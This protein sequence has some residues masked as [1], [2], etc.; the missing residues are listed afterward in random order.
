MIVAFAGGITHIQ[1]LRSSWHSL[2][3]GIRFC[4]IGLPYPWDCVLRIVLMLV[5]SI[6]L[7]EQR[8]Q[9]IRNA[10]RWAKRAA[11][12]VANEIVRSDHSSEYDALILRQN[13]VRRTSLAM[14][15]LEKSSIIISTCVSLNVCSDILSML[16]YPG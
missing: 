15:L 13:N 1:S 7:G 2:S 16:H 9:D 8:L 12:W 11:H 14:A 5:S 4:C 6:R 10:G 3:F